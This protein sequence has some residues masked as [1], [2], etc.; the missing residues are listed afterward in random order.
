MTVSTS[1]TITHKD[2]SGLKNGHEEGAECIK[3]DLLGHHGTDY[4]SL[5][6]NQARLELFLHSLSSLTWQTPC[7]LGV[8][9]TQNN[10]LNLSMLHSLEDKPFQGS[11]WESWEVLRFR[12]SQAIQGL[13]NQL[14]P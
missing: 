11:L 1:D 3:H 7:S 5:L 10:L 14:C 4:E 12:V 9:M 8:N 13:C 2:G 6:N